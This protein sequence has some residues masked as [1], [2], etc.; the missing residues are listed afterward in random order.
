MYSSRLW[1]LLELR[2][3]G[4][5]RDY[6]KCCPKWG[7]NPWPSAYETN[8]LPTE[9]SGHT[10]NMLNCTHNIYCNK[11]VIYCL[12]ITVVDGCEEN[13]YLCQRREEVRSIKWLPLILGSSLALG[14]RS[15]LLNS[16]M[17]LFEVAFAST[18][19]LPVH[20]DAFLLLPTYQV[21][22]HHPRWRRSR[23]KVSSFY[24]WRILENIGEYWRM[25]CKQ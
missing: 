22:V 9:L 25:L 5:H 15:R 8:A 13:L 3:R 4:M 17:N 18:S 21:L 19:N 16:W 2:N 12:Y 11:P 1:L 20:D 6:Q 10:S 23:K 7:S 24:I 14:V